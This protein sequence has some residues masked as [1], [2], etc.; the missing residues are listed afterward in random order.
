MKQI[1]R[2]FLIPTAVVLLSSSAVHADDDLVNGYIGASGSIVTNSYGDCWRTGFKDSS[3]KLQE[4]GYAPEPVV[5]V[6]RVEVVKT[7]TAASVSMKKKEKITLGA[8]MLFGF[9]SAELTTDA[10]AIIMERID[11]F[12]GKG[13]LTSDMQVHGFTCNMGPEEYNQTLSQRRAEAVA[14]YI[15]ENAPNVALEDIKV[16]GKGEEMPV[17]SNDTREGRE[18]NRRVEI[19]AEAEVMK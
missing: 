2:Y 19:F 12:K 14:A 1:T 18:L 7:P 5:E 10:K 17:A 9:D 6:T 4:C 13:K 8:S 16:V 11:R 15:A 3:S